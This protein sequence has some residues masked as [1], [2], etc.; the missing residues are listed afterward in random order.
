MSAVRARVTR[1]LGDGVQFAHHWE[2]LRNG[3][4]DLPE[5]IPLTATRS[6]LHRTPQRLPLTP[7]TTHPPPGPPIGTSKEAEGPSLYSRA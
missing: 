7:R 6:P 5:V 3:T 4:T 2:W 1:T